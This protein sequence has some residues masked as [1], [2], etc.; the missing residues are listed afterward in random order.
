MAHLELPAFS[1]AI[2]LSLLAILAA[3]SVT[4]WLLVR[5]ATSHRQWVAL[6]EWARESGFRFSRSAP[7][8]PPEPFV[9]GLKGMARVRLRLDG[10]ATTLAQLEI[11]SGAVTP[12][13]A[14]LHSAPQ[15]L[16]WNVLIRRVEGNWPPT[17]LR[18]ASAS[19]SVLD[20]FS[21]SS[22]PSLGGTERFVAYGTDTAAARVLS[23][24]SVR[25]L[26]PADI[27]ALVHGPYL[28]LDF[29][30]RPFDAIEFS[31]LLALCEQLVAHLPVVA[32]AQSGR[33]RM[34][35]PSHSAAG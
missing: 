15:P 3:S 11:E 33:G 32:S 28:V 25:S 12:A 1:P 27:G 23:R 24:S 2:L 13:A 31:R 29:S 26:L 9:S 6:S 30:G 8:D 10:R 16:V 34:T 21:L 4:L 18:P 19:G 14:A 17:G 7:T 20:L 5:R 22:F 35:G